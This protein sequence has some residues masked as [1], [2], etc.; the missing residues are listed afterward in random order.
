MEKVQ[1]RGRVSCLGG[2]KDEQLLMEDT[3]L[4]VLDTRTPLYKGH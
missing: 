1:E 2:M 3:N 4:F